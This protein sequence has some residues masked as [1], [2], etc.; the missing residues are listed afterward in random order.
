MDKKVFIETCA[1]EKRAQVRRDLIEMINLYL[2]GDGKMVLNTI[3]VTA[4]RVNSPESWQYSSENKILYKGDLILKRTWW[5][6]WRINVDLDQGLLEE[7]SQ[8]LSELA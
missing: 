4:K 6:S 5:G 3:K 2:N 8:L 7:F 1:K